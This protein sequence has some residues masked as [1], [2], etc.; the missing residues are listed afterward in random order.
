MINSSHS[1]S[2]TQNLL[3]NISNVQQIYLR[4][5]RNGFMIFDINYYGSVDT[6]VEQLAQAGIDVSEVSSKYVKFSY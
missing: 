4:D 2:E 6:F 5:S 1:I 3:R